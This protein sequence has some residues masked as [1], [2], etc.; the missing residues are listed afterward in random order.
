MSLSS[1][2][3][4]T[5]PTRI[6]EVRHNLRLITDACKTDLDGLA[7]EAKALNERKK[8]IID[9]DT[10]LRKKLEEEADRTSV[11][12]LPSDLLTQVSFVVLLRLQQ[13]HLIADE[14]NNQS[15]ELATVY[16]ASLESF[17]PHFS[18]LLDQFPREFDRYRLDEIVVA[19]IAPLVKFLLTTFFTA[20]C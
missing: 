14:I 18:K 9:E 12:L 2:T 7:H 6:P 11:R 3:P 8:W 16:E 19:A 10:R 5:D 1:W 20:D 15:K 17:S 13:V 4:S